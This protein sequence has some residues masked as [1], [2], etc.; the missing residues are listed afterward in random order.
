M[1]FIQMIIKMMRKIKSLEKKNNCAFPAK[2]SFYR[3]ENKVRKKTI[4]PAL[5]ESRV[6]YGGSGC[7]AICLPIPC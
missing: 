5:R 1:F 7:D 3:L 2:F 4:V 6:T